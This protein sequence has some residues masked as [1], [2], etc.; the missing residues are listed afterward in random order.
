MA[1]V[2]AAAQVHPSPPPPAR[3]TVAWLVCTHLAWSTVICL[4]LTS[5]WLYFWGMA[6]KEI[7]RF[8]CGEGCAVVT[9]A[10]KVV[11]VAGVTLMLVLPFSLLGALMMSRAKAAAAVPVAAAAA[12]DITKVQEPALKT[13][14]AAMLKTSYAA[15]RGLLRDPVILGLLASIAF[16]MLM[17]IGLLVIGDSHVMGSRQKRMG[18]MIYV[19]G[20]LGM[21][22]VDC[23]VLCPLMTVRV[24]RS[25]RK[26]LHAL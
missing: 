13:S 16:A 19:V 23:F 8:A 25:L 21:H 17:L 20:A 22:A 15:M 11:Y 7:G 5:L 1:I 6:T 2:A 14:Y 10:Y 9:A 3:H 24:W 12:T 18:S 4:L 26:A